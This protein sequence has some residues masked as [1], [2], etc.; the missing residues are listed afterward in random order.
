MF[1]LTLSLIYT[2]FYACATS[3]DPDQLAHPCHLIWICTGRILVRNNLMNQKAN[4]LTK[5]QKK[6]TSVTAMHLYLSDEMHTF[7]T[8]EIEKESFVSLLE[9]SKTR[10]LRSS[11]SNQHR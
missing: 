6:T 9:E 3:V 1:N 5:K 4:S 8:E 11:G 2:H 7:N 10:V